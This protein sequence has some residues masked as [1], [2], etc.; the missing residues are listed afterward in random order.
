[1]RAGF[2]LRDSRGRLHNFFYS[3]EDDGPPPPDPVQRYTHLPDGDYTVTV[4][5]RVGEPVE[6]RVS[7]KGGVEREVRIRL[8]E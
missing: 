6:E 8:P 7:L 4:R 3:G 1:V 2:D 5:R